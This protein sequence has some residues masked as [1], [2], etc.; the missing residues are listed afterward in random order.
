MNVSI[1]S[2]LGIDSKNKL[3]AGVVIGVSNKAVR[4][5]TFLTKAV[6]S[7]V[8]KNENDDYVEGDHVLILPSSNG[9]NYIVD[10]YNE[11]FLYPQG[12]NITDI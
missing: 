12:S 11:K 8:K 10:K 1:A 6:V 2:S 9:S 7:C 5:R 4:V 3:Y